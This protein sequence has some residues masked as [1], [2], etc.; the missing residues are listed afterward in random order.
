MKSVCIATLLALGLAGAAFADV[1]IKQTTTGKGMGM[2]G[3]TTGTTYIKGNKMR[4]DTVQGDKTLSMVFDIDARGVVLVD[5]PHHGRRDD[6]DE[7]W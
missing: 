3:T 7:T 6:D 4:T 2:S 5:V 1:T